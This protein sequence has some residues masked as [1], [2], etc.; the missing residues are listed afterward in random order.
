MYIILSWLKCSLVSSKKR[1]IMSATVA[2]KT[3]KASL[4]HSLIQ[5][6]KVYQ[7]PRKLF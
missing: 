7:L 1:F 3:C 4:R 2:G 5:S 6:A